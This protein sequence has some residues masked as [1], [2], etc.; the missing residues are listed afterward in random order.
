LR[1][2]VNSL[3]LAVR[4]RRNFSSWL[5]ISSTVRVSS[6]SWRAMLDTSSLSVMRCLHSTGG[7]ARPGAA[8]LDAAAGDSG[9]RAESNRVPQPSDKSRSATR[10]VV[11]L[12]YTLDVLSWMTL[13]KFVETSVRAV[14]EAVLGRLRHAIDAEAGNEE[15]QLSGVLRMLGA[16]SPDKNQISLFGKAPAGQSEA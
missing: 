4:A 1:R 13:R 5:C 2:E 10:R 3:L 6:A 14:D 16:K 12:G 15:E 11:S 9:S 8:T 7:R